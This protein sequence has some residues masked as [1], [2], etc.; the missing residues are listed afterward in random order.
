MKIL[1][2]FQTFKAERPPCFANINS[3]NGTICETTIKPGIGNYL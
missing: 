1:A 3:E 2:K